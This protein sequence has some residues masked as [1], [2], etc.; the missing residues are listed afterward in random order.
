MCASGGH[1]ACGG[2]RW[3]VKQ[4]RNQIVR[5]AQ[6]ERFLLILGWLRNEAA[7]QWETVK[8]I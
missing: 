2:R 8:G 1:D 4:E 6:I 5:R 7:R 3:F